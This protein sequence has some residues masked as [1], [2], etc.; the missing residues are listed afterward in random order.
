MNLAL[1]R[2]LRTSQTRRLL[3]LSDLAY[4]S[5]TMKEP[6]F[7]SSRLIARSTSDLAT[8]EIFRSD[9]LLRLSGR[10][11][12]RRDRTG[13]RTPVVDAPI[14]DD[15]FVTSSFKRSC[16]GR[17]AEDKSLPPFELVESILILV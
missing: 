11:P 16:L 1:S 13:S 4:S 6:C 5:A 10:R 3:M 2:M 14:D 7:S 9:N 15:C 17:V 12:E 8:A